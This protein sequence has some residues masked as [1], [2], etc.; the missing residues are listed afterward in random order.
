[1]PLFKTDNKYDLATRIFFLLFYTAGLI[2][3]VA[4]GLEYMTV[5]A[6]LLAF[7]CSAAGATVYGIIAKLIVDLIRPDRPRSKPDILIRMFYFV[8]FAVATVAFLAIGFQYHTP[9]TWVI[10][11]I[12]SYGAAFIY[13]S[14][15][16]LVITLARHD[17]TPPPEKGTS[18]SGCVIIGDAL[19]S[20]PPNRRLT[21]A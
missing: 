3:F 9:K 8:F 19:A 13:G 16:W 1:M 11:L 20:P 15:A 21:R 14:I 18:P 4:V 2:V 6:W 17:K 7:I 10:A 12:G 5:Q